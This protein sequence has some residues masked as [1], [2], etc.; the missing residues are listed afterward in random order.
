MAKENLY[1]PSETVS[2][3]RLNESIQQIPK[4]KYTNQINFLYT[5]M[6]DNVRKKIISFPYKEIT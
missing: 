5:F 6:Y 2:E 4:M 3:A 1:L